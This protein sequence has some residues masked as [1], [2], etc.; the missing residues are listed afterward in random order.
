MDG[1]ITGESLVNL[2]QDPDAESLFTSPAPDRLGFNK[3]MF[4]DRFKKEMEKLVAK[5]SVYS[6]F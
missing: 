1:D 5:P 3:L 6:Y 2:Y 4:K